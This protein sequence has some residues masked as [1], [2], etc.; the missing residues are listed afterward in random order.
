MIVKFPSTEP[1]ARSTGN[2]LRAYERESLFYQHS[3]A[4]MPTNPPTCYYCHGNVEKDEYLLIIEDFDNARFVNQVDGVN[5]EDAAKCLVS[6]AELHARYWHVDDHEG[7]DWVPL[8]S[9]YGELYKPLLETGT[10]LLK[11][12]WNHILP[13]MFTDELD[14]GVG[15]YQDIATYLCTLPRTLIHCDSRI[16]NVAFVDGEPRFYDWQLVSRGP[17][18]YD[19]M[20][21]FMQSMQ[22]N[23]RHDCQDGLFTLYIDTLIANG[24]TDYSRDQLIEDIGWASCSVFGFLAMCGNFFF[25]SE[26]ND[27]LAGECFP[28]WI[29]MIEDFGGVDKLNSIVSKR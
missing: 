15:A 20:Y 23:L 17:A 7:M 11:K 21:F 8:F 3:E 27:K 18:A 26:V 13:R 1:G 5:A 2:G 16:E 28:R 10:P 14:K 4:G 9:D 22:T 25:R 12:N 19:V 6:L 24:V 29:D